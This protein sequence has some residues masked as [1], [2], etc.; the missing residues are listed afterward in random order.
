MEK[1]EYFSGMSA[2]NI[3]EE[4]NLYITKHHCSVKAISTCC[5]GTGLSFEIIAI[6]VFTDKK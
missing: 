3:S 4:I 6:V 5:S 1:V 2:Y